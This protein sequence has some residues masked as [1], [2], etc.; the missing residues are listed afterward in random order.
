VYD[1]IALD[2][3]SS[4]DIGRG[5]HSQ[6]YFPFRAVRM[7]S[8]ACIFWV[9]VRRAR[10]L[11]KGPDVFSTVVISDCMRSGCLDDTYKHQVHQVFE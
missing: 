8:S 11:A 7:A 2:Y 6:L 1:L 5:Y 4:I 9:P 3:R 10:C